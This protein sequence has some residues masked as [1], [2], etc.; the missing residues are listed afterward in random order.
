M[1]SQFTQK[2]QQ[3]FNEPSS[4]LNNSQL[5]EIQI[6]FTDTQI[7][8]SRQRYLFQ[9]KN[10]KLQQSHHGDSE[11]Q[12]NSINDGTFNTLLE[13]KQQVSSGDILYQTKFSTE[14]NNAPKL[15][16][17]KDEKALEVQIQNVNDLQQEIKQQQNSIESVIFGNKVVEKQQTSNDHPSDVKS[18]SNQDQTNMFA[19]QNLNMNDEKISQVA[20]NNQL[21]NGKRKNVYDN[22]IWL[23]DDIFYEKNFKKLGTKVAFKFKE[24]QQQNQDMIR[25]SKYKQNYLKATHIINKILNT[26]VCRVVRI[27]QHVQSFVDILKLRHFN[28]RTDDLNDY[29]YRSINDLTH[30]HISKNKKI[31]NF[32]IILIINCFERFSKVLPIFMP[33]DLARVIWDMFQVIFTYSFLYLYSLLIFFDQVEFSSQFTNRLFFYSFIIFLVDIAINLNTAIFNKDTIIIKRKLISKQYFLSTIFITDFL[34]LLVLSSKLFNSSQLTVQNEGDN[35]FKYGL[36][37]LIFLKLNGISQKK[38]RFDNIYTL[39]ENQKHIIKLINQIASVITAAHIAAIGWYFL[40]IQEMKSNQTNWLDKLGIQNNAYYEKY[41]YSIYWSIT[42]MTTVGYGDISATNYIEAL[43]ISIAMILFSCVFAY[44]INNIGFILQEIEKSSKQLNDDIT[45]IQR[46]QYIK[47]REICNI[48]KLNLKQQNDQRHLLFNTY[49]ELFTSEQ[50]VTQ[51]QN[52]DDE[53]ENSSQSS[54]ISS[55][56]NEQSED[57]NS[58]ILQHTYSMKK[59]DQILKFQQKTSNISQVSILENQCQTSQ[60]KVSENDKSLSN[61]ESQEFKKDTSNVLTSEVKINSFEVLDNFNI[62]NPNLHFRKKQFLPQHCKSIQKNDQDYLKQNALEIQNLQFEQEKDLIFMNSKKLENQRSYLSL[63]NQFDQQQ[64]DLV[65]SL[66]EQIFL[67]NIIFSSLVFENRVPQQLQQYGI[68]DNICKIKDYF[69]NLINQKMQDKGN[70]NLKDDN[71]K[72]NSIRQ[73]KDQKEK[74]HSNPEQHNNHVNKQNM[75]DKYNNRNSNQLLQQQQLNNK[76]FNQNNNFQCLDKVHNNIQDQLIPLIIQSNNPQSFF[77]TEPEDLFDMT[78][79]FDRVQHFK[80]YFPHN[81]F[82]KVNQMLKKYQLEQKKLKKN[83]I[84]LKQRR[85]NIVLQNNMN[86]SIFQGNSN[87]I[88]LMP[89]DYNIN[90]YKPTY[91]SY[92]VKMQKGNE[93]PKNFNSLPKN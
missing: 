85:Q 18:I 73:I 19:S 48:L 49:E 46:I 23:Q 91:L 79:Q 27:R 9:Q 82:Q 22:D 45:T 38:K 70:Q 78:N 8:R 61:Q 42:T 21:Q 25:L 71:Q 12:E 43:Y 60:E 69:D 81:N 55:N 65:K 59:T 17:E 37:I 24:Q 20:Q 80:R 83:H 7:D 28:K 29:D 93:F 56:L 30:F 14:T 41:V 35:L 13:M 87:F 39:T 2:H 6:Q 44:S 62:N 51:S 90:Q 1:N 77:K 74:R 52:E 11:I 67:Q 72:I 26:S 40:G 4:H 58:K 10:N 63:N 5:D 31:Y 68:Q 86:V 66:K 36:N 16:Q 53:D 92:G 33:T 75:R 57:G 88:R 32:K 89:Q 54:Q 34:S 64:L 15:N 84:G 3:L 47:N 76:A 50:T